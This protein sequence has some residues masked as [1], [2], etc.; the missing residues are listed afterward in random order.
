MAR[1]KLKRTMRFRAMGQLAPET[2]DSGLECDEI[3]RTSPELTSEQ[4]RSFE[5]TETRWRG[6]NPEL[7]TV[8]VDLGGKPRLARIDVD[9]VKVESPPVDLPPGKPYRTPPTRR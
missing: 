9:V 8:I 7:R 2:F 5:Q 3:A 4:R 1:W 6:A